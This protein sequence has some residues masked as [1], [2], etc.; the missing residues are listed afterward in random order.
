MPPSAL[1]H[2][3]KWGYIKHILIKKDALPDYSPSFHS[4][5]AQ[6]YVS[7]AVQTH[8]QEFRQNDTLWSS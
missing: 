1:D 4:R 2:L 3:S 5:Q 6:H 7:N 8:Q